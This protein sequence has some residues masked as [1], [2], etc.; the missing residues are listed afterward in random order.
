MIAA[1]EN[2]TRYHHWVAHVQI[3]PAGPLMQTQPSN[4]PASLMS[5]Q[6]SL[7]V[8]VVQGT[9]HGPWSAVPGPHTGGDALG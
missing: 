8:P 2:E 9:A 5:V 6:T 3:G 1:R 4:L 7:P